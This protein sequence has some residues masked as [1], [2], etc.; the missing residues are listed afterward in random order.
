M[1]RP[2]VAALLAL[3][4]T[5]TAAQLDE[6]VYL[7]FDDEPL[8]GGALLNGSVTASAPVQDFSLLDVPA[9]LTLLSKVEISG[10]LALELS[11]D[12]NGGFATTLDALLVPLAPVELSPGIELVP[13]ATVT[14]TL[15]G[16]A[17]AGMRVSVVQDFAVPVTVAQG[18]LQDLR[19]DEEPE[20]RTRHTA[21]E[22]SGATAVQVAVDVEASLL[23]L[24]VLPGAV[25]PGPA[26]GAELGFDLDVQPGGD[27]W[28]DLDGELRILAGSAAGGTPG[29]ELLG[30][31][32]LDVDDAGEP[33]PPA[34]APSR[35]WSRAWN[36][37]GSETATS[38]APLADGSGELV[39]TG[40]TTGAGG[41]AW[42]ARVA[43]DG[44]LVWEAESF[45]QV[46]GTARPEEIQRT[47][48][49]G[50]LV[51]S[52]TG[53]GAVARVDR[54]T[55]DGLPLWSRSYTDDLGG[56]LGLRSLVAR[57]DGGAVFC[58]QLTRAGQTFPVAAWVAPSGELESAVELTVPGVSFAGLDRVTPTADGGWAFA[59]WIQYQDAGT[60]G[61]A[62]RSALIAKADAG[63]GLVFAR[64]VGG[65]GYDFA[66]D[67]AEGP[68]GELA[69]IGQLGAGGA[70]L[71][72]TFWLDAAG[73]LG[74]TLHF[75]DAPGAG[76]TA[77]SSIDALPGGGFLVAG[78]RGLGAAQD[79]WLFQLDDHGLPLWW[80]TI[81]GGEA[82]E[83]REARVLDDGVLLVGLTRSVDDSTPIPG[84]DYW[85]MRAGVEGM[86]HFDASLGFD[87]TNPV[88][89][90][91]A[92]SEGSVVVVELPA[93]FAPAPASA[94]DL[95]LTPVATA[96]AA[97]VLAP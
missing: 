82:D 39:L 44:E 84:S 67:L 2:L 74:S 10:S 76:F 14:V 80:K 66:V 61:L 3:I 35:R 9:G 22:V 4:P 79:A 62:S 27:P 57:P 42:F 51:G 71:A 12:A 28:W 26:F 65:V 52:N 72:W 93:T 5:P 95:V 8:G 30:E 6:G 24:I 77:L 13:F 64:A 69:A 50:F 38:A 78:L 70:T 59:G 11:A 41:T 94:N 83:P 47:P 23:Y 85:A 53:V 81:A 90:R 89:T 21:P 48:D 54:L 29:L 55:A 58:G 16:V 33:L 43:A 31:Q 91:S 46:G 60:P 68:D 73:E 34:P 87:A 7:A 18:G 96:A 56:T 92:S 97:I 75:T 25:L 17:E 86:L 15:A 88:P 37:G 63:G 49:G 1:P 32:E 20:L 40:P 36:L 19:L 45:F